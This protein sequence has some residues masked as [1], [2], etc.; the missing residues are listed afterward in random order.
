M[1]RAVGLPER[2]GLLVRGVADDSPAAASGLRQGDLIVEAGGRE[3]ATADD[4][5]EALDAAGPTGSMALKVLR[6]SEERSVS[7]AL[8][9][10]PTRA[11]E[12]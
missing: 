4:L 11:E 5:F 12:A 1:R 6:G 9:G 2:E 7:V 3:V 10:R 8:A